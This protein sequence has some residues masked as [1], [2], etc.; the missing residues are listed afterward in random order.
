MFFAFACKKDWNQNRS[1]Q[2]QSS[3]KTHY[4]KRISFRITVMQ[5]VPTQKIR[6]TWL[7]SLQWSSFRFHFNNSIRDMKRRLIGLETRMEEKKQ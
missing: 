1:G 2:N 5:R 4:S 6:L 3:F 7:E